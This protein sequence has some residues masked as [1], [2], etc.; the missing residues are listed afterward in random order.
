MNVLIFGTPPV[1]TAE[2]WLCSDTNDP[3]VFV[4]TMQQPERR[5]K[6]LFFYEAATEIEDAG[7][8]SAESNKGVAA[9]SMDQVSIRIL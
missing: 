7:S 1:F 2:E 6:R 8:S 4:M 3:N 5:T 9:H